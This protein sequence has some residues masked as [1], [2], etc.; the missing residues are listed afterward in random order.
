[1]RHVLYAIEVV[2]PCVVVVVDSSLEKSWGVP[3]LAICVSSAMLKI[4]QIQ[5]LASLECLEFRV[6]CVVSVTSLEL[7]GVV[8]LCSRRV[9]RKR[10]RCRWLL[11]KRVSSVGFVLC[12][13]C[14]V[15]VVGWE[16]LIVIPIES[17]T[18]SKLLKVTEPCFD[19]FL[20][21]FTMASRLWY[22]RCFGVNL[23]L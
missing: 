18:V 10:A 1:M 15:V 23:I 22:G 20:A 6:L 2:H 16:L 13:R 21:R 17:R 14:E 9:I 12:R 5:L 11:K 7:V 3:D 19:G 4:R 8:G